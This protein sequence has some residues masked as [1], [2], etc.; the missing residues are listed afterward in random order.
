MREQYIT[1][2]RSHC[3]SPSM[4]NC[5]LYFLLLPTG[6]ACP[7]G[8]RCLFKRRPAW[9]PR[10]GLRARPPLAMIFAPGLKTTLNTVAGRLSPFLTCPRLN[11]ESSP[12]MIPSAIKPPTICIF[13]SVSGVKIGRN[14]AVPSF[15]SINPTGET[16][17]AP[18]I[19]LDSESIMRG[20]MIAENASAQDQVLLRAT[21]KERERD[22]S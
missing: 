15:T 14:L 12:L 11:S 18:K 3:M 1:I 2:P 7:A 5:L 4:Q 6:R 17:K 20:I 10:S 9:E 13:S 22:G 8:V 21:V 16:D 19:D